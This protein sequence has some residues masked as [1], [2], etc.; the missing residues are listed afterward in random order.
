[1]VSCD[2]HFKNK[3]VAATRDISYWVGGRTYGVDV[4]GRTEGVLV[5]RA[6]SCVRAIGQLAGILGN[7]GCHTCCR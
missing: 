3:R 7:G 6:Y 4:V 2:V 1:M 5:L